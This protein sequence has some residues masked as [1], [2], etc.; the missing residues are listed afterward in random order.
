[1]LNI[2]KSK[3]GFSLVEVLV[4]AGLIGVVATG[5]ISFSQFLN[6][7]KK[8]SSVLDTII[9]QRQTIIY[10]LRSSDALARTGL[11][12]VPPI[13]CL[14]TLQTCGSATPANAQYMM[15]SVLDRTGGASSNL[16]DITPNV[17]FG[18]DGLTCTTYPSIACPLRYEV[19]WKALCSGAGCSAPQFMMLGRLKIDN[20]GDVGVPINSL[21]LGFEI[22][23]GQMLGTYE[24]ACTSLG[25]TYIP[26]DPPG[27]QLPAAGDCL[28]VA[29]AE[30]R[31][32][33]FNQITK[34]PICRPYFQNYFRG[35]S[36]VPG[37]VMVG[38]DASF[39]PICVAIKPTTNL[40]IPTNCQTFPPSP[41]CLGIQANPILGISDG[42]GD[43][44][45]GSGD[46]CN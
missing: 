41:A 3:K 36:C 35:A 20:P 18:V 6:V 7:A 33:G 8:K 2:L 11:A 14:Q 40:S 19:F 44:G 4:A 13:N 22:T 42:G 46:G 25:G 10:S 23:L 34:A 38:T 31:V 32:V 17:G 9:K 45:C 26:I 28:P 29:G 30:Q 43:G 16:T 21:E 27:C 24:Q 39:N 5:L 12:N 37:Q 1:M 15:I